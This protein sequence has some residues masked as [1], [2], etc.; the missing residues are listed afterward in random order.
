MVTI[1][2]K[3]NLT[4][5]GQYRSVSWKNGLFEQSNQANAILDISFCRQQKMYEF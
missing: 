5:Q 1:A 3:N 2:E 4:L